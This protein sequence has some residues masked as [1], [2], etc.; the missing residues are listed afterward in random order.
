MDGVQEKLSVIG[1]SAFAIAIIKGS[2][3]LQ[4]KL[5]GIRFGEYATIGYRCARAGNVV[6]KYF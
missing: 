6:R 1:Q 3:K 5:E 4:V 2:S